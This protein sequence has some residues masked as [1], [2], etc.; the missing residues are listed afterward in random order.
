MSDSFEFISW[1]GWS[2]YPQDNQTLAQVL[3][4]GNTT[5]AYP[6]VFSD[7]GAAPSTNYEI[8][9]NGTA[10]TFNAPT[11]AS[12]SVTIN[13]AQVFAVSASAITVPS[14][15][16]VFTGTTSVS[17]AN[18]EFNSNSTNTLDWNVPS[19]GSYAFRLNGGSTQGINN[20]NY[21]FFNC[22][23]TAQS[24]QKARAGGRIGSGNGANSSG[25]TET[26]LVSFAVGASVLGASFETIEAFAWGSFAAN[27]NNKQIKVYFGSTTLYDSTAQAVNSGDYMLNIRGIR[28]GASTSKWVV[29]LQ[30][31]SALYTN[32]VQ[33]TT[34][35][36]SLSSSNNLRITGTGTSNNDITCEAYYINWFAPAP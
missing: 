10:L 27:A 7:V 5:G 33:V 23:G 6:I 13:G 16:I 31:E 11:G 20:A 36:D 34:A 8:R 9:R 32:T 28:T 30:S 12:H 19:T 1:S 29:T 24:S 22:G 18:K 4:Q 21:F 17:S 2:G 35:S 14:N 3:A 26:D 15:K 25:S